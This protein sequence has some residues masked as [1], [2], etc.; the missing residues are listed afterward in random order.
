[1]LKRIM[2]KFSESKEKLVKKKKNVIK[3]E[4]SFADFQSLQI[5]IG[6][7]LV[8]MMA[9]LIKIDQRDN[10]AAGQR[11]RVNSV[12]FAKVAKTFRKASLQAKKVEKDEE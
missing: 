2:K 9:D 6:D 7:L 3:T 8:A 4:L 1:M 5:R 11:F 10:K 12:K